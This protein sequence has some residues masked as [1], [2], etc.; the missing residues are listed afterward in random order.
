MTRPEISI[1]MPCLNSA[2]YISE[3]IA[4]VLAQTFANFE[5]IAVDGGSTDATLDIIERHAKKDARIT[6]VH[7]ERKSMGA[8]YNLGL[9]ASKGDCIG[10]VES[11]DCIDARMYEILRRTIRDNDV[12]FV[13]SDFD[14]FV[15][16]SDG[17]LFFKT[18]PVAENRRDCY[19]RILDSEELPEL[20]RRDIFIWNGLYKRDFIKRNRIRFNETPGAAF[21]DAGFVSQTLFL[22]ERAIYVDDSLY[23]YR[24]GNDASSSAN[25]RAYEFV[26]NEFEY[27]VTKLNENAEKEYLFLP[28]F[29]RR[30]FG[31]FHNCLR[32]YLYR[33]GYTAEL[34]E[35]VG[36]FRALFR[37][38][39]ESLTFPQLSRSDLWPP[40]DLS[41]FFGDFELYCGVS[42]A[43]YLGNISANRSAAKYLR[44]QR[45]ILI[46]G[47]GENAASLYC[48]LKRCGLDNIVAFC[49][50]S[51]PGPFC[52]ID[53][54]D[55]H[56]AIRRFP[57]A[58]YVLSQSTNQIECKKTLRASGIAPERIV[59]CGAGL[60]HHNWHELPIG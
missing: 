45:E 7:S 57:N 4:G 28:A 36:P 22:A 17:R 21:Q 32:L 13:K 2:P 40:V 25:V 16:V 3:T 33:V 12:D 60:F 1:I 53:A 20:A 19:G 58:V 34:E 27:T 10:F 9:R 43:Q 48:Y 29:L 38:C 56:E 37:K 8:Q 31:A 24:K 49:S 35:R 47:V 54:I 52:G 42:L 26:M 46:C 11:D 5:L 59:F 23:L 44:E 14:V 15:D 39:Y 51:A 6:L 55:R 30:Y 18:G 41:L 50:D